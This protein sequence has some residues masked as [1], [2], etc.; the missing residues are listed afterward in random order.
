[1]INTIHNKILFGCAFAIML[2]ASI[3]I[4]SPHSEAADCVPIT[5]MGRVD[6]GNYSTNQS[7]NNS[8]WVRISSSTP[9]ALR[10]NVQA[11]PDA[12][13]SS[14][15][16]VLSPNPTSPTIWTWVKA[17][18]FNATSTGNKISLLGVDPGIRVDRVI[19]FPASST[20]VPS[21]A[22]VTTGTISEPGDNC[23]P[24][25]PPP[26]N[27]V[28]STA[29]V[30]PTSLTALVQS[31]KQIN[32]QW[33]L[34][35]DNV[36]IKNYEILRNNV[37]ITTSTAN[38]FADTGLSQQTTYNYKVIAVDNANNKSTG[39][40]KTATTQKSPVDS[41]PPKA[42]TGLNDSVQ[43]DPS[44]GYF[45]RLSWKPSVDN[46]GIQDYIVKRNGSIIGTTETTSFND[47]QFNQDKYV[48]YQV[49]ARDKAG[50]LSPETSDT[51]VARCFLIFC[52]EE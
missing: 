37:L 20:C 44:K 34:A 5:G 27:I 10:L 2:A 24:K 11:T 50:N 8:L 4:N 14:C 42:P 39:A 1:M 16:S 13:A 17:G 49:Q 43:F 25:P 18:T 46:T 22:R 30:G 31:D 28:D 35:T 23:L 33:P 52:W 40:S 48:T 12:G 47:F 36:G 3:F 7:G 32:L 26:P 29:P 19:I 51:I 21:N 6:T 38:S 15:F 41:T 9:T 45:V